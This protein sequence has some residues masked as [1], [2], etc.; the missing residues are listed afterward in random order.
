M[1]AASEANLVWLKN[2][3]PLTD[4]EFYK[5]RLGGTC[6]RP[7]YVPC[8]V[9][10]R[11]GGELTLETVDEPKMTIAK[12]EAD[13]LPS[14]SRL[15]SGSRRN[16][17]E[18]ARA[19]HCNAPS[20]VSAAHGRHVAGEYWTYAGRRDGP[21]VFLNPNGPGA[22]RSESNFGLLQMQRRSGP[23]AAGARDDAG[24]AAKPRYRT[25]GADRRKGRFPPPAGDAAEAEQPHLYDAVADAVRRAFELRAPQLLSFVGESGSGKSE[26]AKLAL[27]FAAIA[28]GDP[29]FLGVAAA[30]PTT[31]RLGGDA[32][33]AARRD[34]A[35]Q[36]WAAPLGRAANPLFFSGPEARGFSSSQARAAKKLLSTPTLVEA[37]SCARSG[38]NANA[39]R[40]AT[41]YRL[42]VRPGPRREALVAGGSCEIYGLEVARVARSPGDA[43]GAADGNFHALHWLAGGVE[44]P[45]ERAALRLRDARDKAGYRLLDATDDAAA[46][47]AALSAAYGVVARDG[48]AKSKRPTGVRDSFAEG[49][50]GL[51]A[52]ILALGDVEFGGGDEAKYRETAASKTRAADAAELLGVDGGVLRDAFLCRVLD[53]ASGASSA[54]VGKRVPARPSDAETARDGLIKALYGRLVTWVVKRASGECREAA[55]APSDVYVLDACGFDDAAKGAG[56]R[57][58]FDELLHN[59]AAE[60]HHAYYAE[61]TFSDELKLYDDEGLDVSTTKFPAVQTNADVLDLLLGG[62][63]SL[64][65][66]VDASAAALGETDARALAAVVAAH[67]ASPSFEPGRRQRAATS[68]TVKHTGGDV[69]YDVHD[70]LRRARVAAP[71]AAV[72][73][74]ETSTRPFVR[75]LFA[76]CDVDEAACPWLTLGDL[77][78]CGAVRFVHA[79]EQGRASAIASFRSQL[80]ALYGGLSQLG[81]LSRSTGRPLATHV[82]CTRAAPQRLFDKDPELARDFF[83]PSYVG[84]QLFDRFAVPE[85]ATLTKIGLRWRMPHDRF[86]AKYAIAA[87]GLGVYSR[88]FPLVVADDDAGERRERAK[89]LLDA[90]LCDPGLAAE[91]KEAA[92]RGEAQLG[93]TLVMLS[94][95]LAASLERRL[96]DATAIFANCATRLAAMQ[97]AREQRRVYVKVRNGL[98]LV[99]ALV[100]AS[101]KF[102]AHWKRILVVRRFRQLRRAAVVAQRWARSRFLRFWMLD[103]RLA[104][105]VLAGMGRGAAG[106]GDARRRR[107]AAMVVA[108]RFALRCVRE[109]EFLTL[110]EHFGDADAVAHCK[111]SNTN[112][113]SPTANEYAVDD[114][115]GDPDAPVD[116][117]RSS[118]I[119]KG[120]QRG[121]GRHL[122]HH[123]LEFALRRPLPNRAAKLAAQRFASRAELV[124]VDARASDAHDTYP[125]G[126]ART[127][128]RLCRDL[129]RG[130]RRL[131]DVAVGRSHSA[132]LSDRGELYTWGLDDAGQLG[133]PAPGSAAA[134]K[135][136]GEAHVLAPAHRDFVVAPAT[137]DLE[138]SAHGGSR[139]L[140]A[141]GP[142]YAGRGF[143]TP[144]AKPG[145]AGQPSVPAPKGFTRVAF[146]ALSAGADFCV[147]LSAGGRLFAWGDNRRGQ[148]GLG[149]L[150]PRLVAGRR[151]GG[152]GLS[153]RR[154]AAVACGGHF[155]VCVAN[156]GVVFSWGARECLGIDGGRSPGRDA[157]LRSPA[158]RAAH[159][160]PSPTLVRGLDAHRKRFAWKVACGLEFSVVVTRVG[161]RHD[162][163]AWGNNDK[164]QLGLGDGARRWAPE[165]LTRKAVATPKANASATELAKKFLRRAADVACGSRH[166]LVLAASGVVLACGH[167]GDGQLGVGDREDR[168]AYAVVRGRLAKCPVT[169]IVAGWRHSAAL[170]ARHELYAWGAAT[171]V[172]SSPGEVADASRARS[173][174]HQH[175]APRE[176]TA[177]EAA[178]KSAEAAETYD[179]R[180]RA[181]VDAAKAKKLDAAEAARERE[182]IDDAFEASGA[183]RDWTAF[184][185][186]SPRLVP[187]PGRAWRVPTALCAASSSAL[188]AT[189]VRYAAIGADAEA[190]SYAK[191]VPHEL[192][193][194]PESPQAFPK[195]GD[196]DGRAEKLD[197]YDE[198]LRRV[199]DRGWARA[200]DVV[201]DALRRENETEEVEDGDGGFGDVAWKPAT[202]E[203]EASKVAA[204][205]RREREEGF[206]AAERHV[207]AV[208]GIGA[209][210]SDL[211]RGW[212]A[213]T[214]KG[215]VSATMK[216]RIL[217]QQLRDLEHEADTCDA[218]AADTVGDETT[219]RTFDDGDLEDLLPSDD[220]DDDDDDAHSVHVSELT[221]KSDDLDARAAVLKTAPDSPVR[222]ADLF[223]SEFLIGASTGAP[224]SAIRAARA[225][226]DGGED[227]LFADLPRPTA[228]PPK[229][230]GRRATYRSALDLQ[231]RDDE[232]ARLRAAP[233]AP[234]VDDSNLTEAA[235]PTASLSPRARRPR[236]RAAAAGGTAVD[237]LDTPP[238]PDRGAHA[239]LAGKDPALAALLHSMTASLNFAEKAHD[240]ERAAIPTSSSGALVDSPAPPRSAASAREDAAR[241]V[242]GRAGA[243]GAYG[244]SAADA[245]RARARA[246]S[247]PEPAAPRRRP[248]TTTSPSSPATRR[249]ANP[250]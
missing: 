239:A 21:L 189:I 123:A 215:A 115:K 228:E 85:F 209:E 10:A 127:L 87:R 116:A 79:K 103:A 83:E 218:V 172:A 152:G 94:S 207:R 62:P 110:A 203:Q 124:D 194:P 39:S 105:T 106:R 173:F 98:G 143:E 224:G 171:C 53:V 229:H 72:A 249:P 118:T 216:A 184:S 196:G 212:C 104:A 246:L 175:F 223:A 190:L 93:R 154:V 34:D 30:G 245:A 99:V 76:E 6:G 232:E 227:P 22:P 70:L 163:F 44:S 140:G 164:G 19:T 150:L 197:A 33:V 65:G 192:S 20:V 91:A 221:L 210:A 211:E 71:A 244:Y 138:V 32:L 55:R 28:F 222:V 36:A 89:R 242:H 220:D 37:F 183:R 162:L 90:L 77:A 144:R 49:V 29:S 158:W 235:R 248:P 130:G 9:V 131:G 176:K 81:G 64:L 17:S 51:L 73:A 231:H 57:N 181:A 179:A 69:S 119:R 153:R 46:D 202:P 188:S 43:E 237:P 168:S 2:P 129:G 95:P 145:A 4:G 58:F 113:S 38:R 27:E 148:C 149:D 1:D 101:T 178:A 151:A 75:A 80:D 88:A 92:R 206:T 134:A 141:A 205:K 26:S 121:A 25:P 142:Q 174:Y 97:R 60:R 128:G 8:R 200:V 47:W 14:N 133:R 31:S 147:A 86:Y 54:G 84:K 219:L 208:F 24:G 214:K 42:A 169:Q 67:G 122:G 241:D 66:T 68:F 82:L 102:G 240:R 157:E 125:H 18:L 136:D 117:C 234:D 187:F 146:T 226:A 96:D 156:P 111:C 50:A 35:T 126:W 225:A 132:A 191:F 201:A 41:M 247:S 108:E 238:H 170:T 40:G 12:R 74:L 159:D 250:F 137:V 56:G 23:R 3:F 204:A 11:N 120:E 16:L 52:A 180:K 198:V 233:P 109:R 48:D 167:N 7:E 59:A 193:S 139:A 166:A 13:V 185:V 195:T 230:L 63:A 182:A 165:M 161:T 160:V 217:A 135:H 45:S 100:K 213:S 112:L 5:K 107:V 61:T 236:R 243:Y 114:T 199:P 15:R 155:A 177:A 78:A 186:A